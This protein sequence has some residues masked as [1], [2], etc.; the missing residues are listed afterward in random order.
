MSPSDPSS[1]RRRVD[2]LH[3]GNVCA[4]PLPAILWGRRE[5]MDL[6]PLPYQLRMVEYLRSREAAVWEWYGSQPAQE[7]QAATLRLELLKATIRLDATTHAAL[8]AAAGRAAQALALD[9]QTTFYQAIGREGTANASLVWLPEGAHIVLSGDLLG[10]L[11]E[12]EMETLVAHE[13]GHLRLWRDQEG[14]F[15]RAL[16]ILGDMSTHPRAEPSVEKSEVVFRQCCEIYADRAAL[17]ATGDLEAVIA[18]LVKVETGLAV[19]NPRA[20]LEQAAEIFGIERPKTHGLTHPESYVRVHALA[21]WEGGAESVDEEIERII[22]GPLHAD[23]LD[24]M[25]QHRLEKLTADLLLVL[26]GPP[27]TRSE[28]LL[29]HARLFFSEFIPSE[30]LPALAGLT[31]QVRDADP[32]IL[33]YIAYLLLDFASADP[34]MNELPLAHALEI[35]DGFSIRG[36][37]E[38]KAAK[39][40][41]M[42]KKAIAAL[43]SEGRSLLARAAS[44]APVTG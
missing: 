34:A 19:V 12:A 36:R 28:A 13:L 24:L 32:S 35:A 33:D 30:R 29:A 3:A 26:F 27:W 17:V 42:S 5:S 8:Y 21:Q 6:K 20:Y 43:R 11:S 44:A 16:R 18:C 41:R 39:E 4:D 25:D 14:D 15:F 38:E 9:T 37:V 1:S 40:L 7:A 2:S 22:A 23:R 31:A 10:S